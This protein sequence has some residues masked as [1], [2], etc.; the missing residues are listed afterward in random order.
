MTPGSHV[1]ILMEPVLVIPE[2][3]VRQLGAVELANI[4]VMI[5]AV[6]L[7]EMVMEMCVETDNAQAEKSAIPVLTVVD[8]MTMVHAMEMKIVQVA[9]W[10][11]D[12]V[13]FV[14]MEHVIQQVKTVPIV[15]QIVE[16]AL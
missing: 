14:A 7:V 15:R 10:I 12:H 4:V 1:K 11:A 2:D 3:Y 13:K 9:M 5:I 8:A 6:L 16:Y